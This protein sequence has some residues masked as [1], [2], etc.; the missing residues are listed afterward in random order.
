MS[1]CRTEKM[2]NTETF[3][4]IQNTGATTKVYIYLHYG[5]YGKPSVHL[6][7]SKRRKVKI[8]CIETERTLP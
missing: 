3:L 1:E 7:N 6:D 8:K 2:N 5:N 4:V